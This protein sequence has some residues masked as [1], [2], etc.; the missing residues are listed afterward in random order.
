MRSERSRALVVALLIA[1]IAAAVALPVGPSGLVLADD[2][3][4]Q[5]TDKSKKEGVPAQCAR[6]IKASERQRCLQ[7][8][9]S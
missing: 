5:A 9:G 6:L 8:S 2:K 3:S 1:M 7:K 4:K